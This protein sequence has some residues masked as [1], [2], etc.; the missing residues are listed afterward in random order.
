[1]TPRNRP[2]RTLFS[3][4]LLG[5]L[6]MEVMTILWQNDQCTVEVVKSQLP[7]AAA[8]MTVLTTL[9]RLVKK[10]LLRQKKQ[11]NRTLVYSPVRSQKEW[12]RQAAKAA[13]ERFLATP[14]VPRE[15]LLSILRDAATGFP[16]AA[17]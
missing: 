6:E 4:A 12:Q 16:S 2:Q 1:M 8:Y 11:S 3:G 14:N 13:V 17:D 9:K 7:R 15:L 5:P 10:R